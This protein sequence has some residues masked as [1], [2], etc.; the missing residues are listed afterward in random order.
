MIRSFAR[1]CPGLTLV[2]LSAVLFTRAGFGPFG[3]PAQREKPCELT[4]CR[5]NAAAVGLTGVGLLLGAALGRKH[6]Q[7]A[8]AGPEG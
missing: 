3:D 4:R 8:A 6:S 2:A 7:R 5:H 1:Y